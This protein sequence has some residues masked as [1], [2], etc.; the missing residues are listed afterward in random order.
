MDWLW[1]YVVFGF[2]LIVFAIYVT[3]KQ[4]QA[5]MDFIDAARSVRAGMSKQDVISILGSDYSYSLLK[6]GI[7]KLEWL[8][9]STACRAAIKAGDNI[10][11]LEMEDLVKKVLSDDEVRYCPHGRP[12]LFSMSEYEIKKLF[13]RNG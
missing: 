4:K 8:Y 12:V 13:G 2:T 9:H 1:L 3:A 6:N 7:E 5:E 11:H 10:S